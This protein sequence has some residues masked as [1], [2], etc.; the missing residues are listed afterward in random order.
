MAIRVTPDEFARD[1]RRRFR[2]LPKTVE[3]AM[4]IAAHRGRTLLVQRTPVDTG[5]MKNAWRVDPFDLEIINDAPHA[6]IIEGG[7]RRHKVNRAGR[8]AIERWAMRKLG[9]DEETAK[10]ISWGVAKKLEREGQEGKFI[11]R[12]SMPELQKMVIKEVER[13]I[14][15]QAGRKS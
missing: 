8:L 12:D 9:V 1:I 15:A 3:T 5:Q 6:G 7:A 2:K 10:A 14:R 11:T 4:K 13:R